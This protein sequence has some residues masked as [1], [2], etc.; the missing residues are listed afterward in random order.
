MTNIDR[1]IAIDYVLG[2]VNE[3]TGEILT[4]NLDILASR[5]NLSREYLQH[6]VEVNKLDKLYTIIQSKLKIKL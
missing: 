6:F 2:I 3:D 1:N 4:R 5:Y